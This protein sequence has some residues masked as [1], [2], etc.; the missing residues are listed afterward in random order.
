MDPR[1]AETLGP[2]LSIEMWDVVFGGMTPVKPNGAAGPANAVVGEQDT[3]FAIAA[4][5]QWLLDEAPEAIEGE[6]GDFTTLKVAM[7][8]K[9]LGVSE[10]VALDLMLE[11][12][13]GEKAVPPWDGEDLAVKVHNA[14]RYGKHA[15]G[16]ASAEA[17]FGEGPLAPGDSRFAG[18]DFT[19]AR[20]VTLTCSYLIKGL[21][22]ENT[23][24]VLYGTPGAGK[25][26]VAIDFAI[27]I[28]AGLPCQGR[29]VK[30]GLVVY[31]AMEG[32]VGFRRRLA[33]LHRSRSDIPA[34]P[35][36]H[37]IQD[38]F[39]IRSKKNTAAMVEH[40]HQVEKRFGQR[41]A[42]VVVDTLAKAAPGFDENAFQGMSE[43]VG[44]AEAIQKALGCTILLV[45]HS[46]KNVQQGAR[47]HSAL[48]GAVD[49]EI[50]VET[51]QGAIRVMKTHKQRD[52]DA[53]QEV[54]F[55]LRRIE[56]GTDTDGDPVGSCVVDWLAANEFGPMGLSPAAEEMWEAFQVAAKEQ[57]GVAEWRSAEVS[58]AEWE[59]VFIDLRGRGESKVITPRHMKRL[60]SETREAG[61]TERRGEKYVA[62][63]ES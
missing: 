33:A 40:I 24:A 3:D 6:G 23:L 8:L 14:Y 44:G 10:P 12:W 48:K 27:S 36:L 16:Y 45:H 54:R 39:N 43:V 9:D 13:N 42:M 55:K 29:H 15:P 11:H 38:R 58:V 26:F 61:Y 22:D 63:S 35:A 20:E 4:A 52:G 51:G 59:E 50:Q 47:G 5:R 60:R 18:Y 41:C 17:E 46:G 28:A 21:I 7:R 49:T 2:P 31:V 32:P 62:A 57:K 37:V 25:T 1:L 30:K 56:L 34:N 53:G 19:D